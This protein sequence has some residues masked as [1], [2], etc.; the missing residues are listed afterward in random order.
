[1]HGRWLTAMVQELIVPISAN[2][3]SQQGPLRQVGGSFHPQVQGVQHKQ[4]HTQGHAWDSGRELGWST[5]SLR[6]I[7]E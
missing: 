5:G 6:I 2:Q 1:M 3:Q 4:T 7:K